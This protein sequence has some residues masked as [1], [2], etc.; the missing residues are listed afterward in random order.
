MTMSRMP[1]IGNQWW[2]DFKK[3][4]YPCDFIVVNGH[5]QKPPKYYR[6]FLEI[7]DEN[8]MKKVKQQDRRQAR[9]NKQDRTHERLMVIEQC[10][11][12]KIQSRKL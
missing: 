10:T 4:V 8:T 9:R 3:E 12:A 6:R 5:K 1:G 2:N 7:E 11:K